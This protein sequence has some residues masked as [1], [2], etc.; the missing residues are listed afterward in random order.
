MSIMSNKP[1]TYTIGKCEKPGTV[2]INL[3]RKQN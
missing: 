3:A 1:E 2:L